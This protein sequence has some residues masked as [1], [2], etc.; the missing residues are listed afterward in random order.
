MQ[1]IVYPGSL[2][3]GTD[4]VPD[5]DP[6]PDL[7]PEKTVTISGKNMMDISRAVEILNGRVQEW[8]RINRIEGPAIGT[9]FSGFVSSGASYE[10]DSG[11]K[12]GWI[13]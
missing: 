9:V 3:Q 6:H 12:G 11:S 8:R 4:L 2:E 10:S 13:R 1:D 5:P 7:D